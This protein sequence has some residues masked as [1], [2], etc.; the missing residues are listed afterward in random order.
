MPIE[1]DLD[2][3]L[4]HKRDLT[5]G[6][7]LMVGRGWRIIG[8][9]KNLQSPLAYSSFEFRCSIERILIEFFVLIRNKKYLNRISDR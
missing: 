3:I 2:K 5:S 1:F 6:Y 8:E 4:H 7:H 9:E